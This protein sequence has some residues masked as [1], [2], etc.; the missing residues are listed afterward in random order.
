MELLDRDLP[1]TADT[2]VAAPPEAPETPATLL[3]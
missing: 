1:E 2:T 3:A